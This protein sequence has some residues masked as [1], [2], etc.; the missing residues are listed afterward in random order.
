MEIKSS[1]YMSQNAV[2]NKYKS[3]FDPTRETVG[4]IARDAHLSHDGYPIEVGEMKAAIL[5]DLV[6]DINEALL[7][8]RENPFYLLVTE[9]KDLQIKNSIARSRLIFDYRPWPEDNTLVFWKNPKTQE[10]RFCW[11]LPHWSEMDNILRNSWMYSHELIDDIVAWKTFK[12][13][14]FG[15]YNHPKHKWIP[16]PKHIDRK[17]Q[18]NT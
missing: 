2:E 18:K 3:H 9:K 15:F 8:P 17:L 12:M 11:D 6:N 13:E 5:P 10:V 14:H 7:I 1:N 4:K 16:N